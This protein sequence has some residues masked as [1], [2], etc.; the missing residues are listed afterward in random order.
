M[1]NVYNIARKEFRGY[2]GSPM[3]YIV[4]VVFLGVVNWMFF[5]NFFISGQAGLRTMFFYLPMMFI[6]LAPAI[7]MRLWAEEKKIGTLEILMTLPLKDHEA[8]LGKYLA[9]FAFL[10]LNL[11]L[12]FTLVLTVSKLGN[13]DTG[14]IIGGYAGALLMGGAYL[15]VGSFT[16]SITDNQIVAFILGVT[17]SFV[18]FIIGDPII[19]MRAPD[20]LAPV[21]QYLSMGAHFENIERGVI[22]TRDVAYYLS[23]IVFFLLMTRAVIEQRR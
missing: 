1:V 10:A 12:T 17:G 14:P 15:A 11:A 16:S 18:L 5:Q 2:F 9:S 6:I 22:D 21:L 23:V 13:P 19:L 20:A 8:V 3:A 4:L 7:T